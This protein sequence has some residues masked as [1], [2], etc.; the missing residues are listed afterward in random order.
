MRKIIVTGGSGKASRATIRRLLEHGYEVPNLNLVPSPDPVA[1]FTHIELT[2]FGETI[3]ALSRLGGR[4]GMRGAEAIVHLGAIPTSAIQSNEA[5]F[6]INAVSTYNVFLAAAKLGFERVV[7]ASSET[8]LGLHCD[9]APPAYAPLDEEAPVLPESSYVLTKTLGEE[10]ARQFGRWHP[11]IPFL[12]L[13]F[14]NIMEP[15]EY[16][17]IAGFQNDPRVR[18]WNLWV[19][20][21]RAR[22]GAILPP[23]ARGGGE[24]GRGLHHPHR[25]H[26]DG[27][28][29]R[30]AHGRGVP[31]DAATGG[32]RDARYLALNREGAPYPGLR[33]PT[34]LA[35]S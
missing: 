13:R 11:D 31:A 29:K 27:A 25:G 26:G 28:D 5:T 8:A 3:D 34:F 17:G 15:W 35:R 20:C 12:G 24:R 14:S 33:A 32:D 7:W 23:R 2:D 18:K 30:G 21:R 9:R 1:P 4:T 6:H 22:R 10:T 19:L 16:E